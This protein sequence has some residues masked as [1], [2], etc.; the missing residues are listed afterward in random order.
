MKKYG[1][2]LD[3][4]T[5]LDARRNLLGVIDSVLDT[6]RTDGHYAFL[7]DEDYG[8]LHVLGGLATIDGGTQSIEVLH[9]LTVC[10]QRIVTIRRSVV[11]PT[12]DRLYIEPFTPNLFEVRGPSDTVLED[13]KLVDSLVKARFFKTMAMMA[14]ERFN[15]DPGHFGHPPQL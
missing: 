2:S 9:Q 8:M 1:S 10:D 11:R 3:V 13:E 14:L 5:A 12:L 6:T 4:Q 7:E 15:N